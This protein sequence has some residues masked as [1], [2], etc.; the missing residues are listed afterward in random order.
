MRPSSLCFWLAAT[1]S[2]SACANSLAPEELAPRSFTQAPLTVDNG[3]DLNGKDLNGK[4]L[5]GSDLSKFMV[6]VNFNPAKKGG[7]TLDDAWLEG[8]TFY[9]HK[10]SNIYLGEEFVGV[11]FQGN[12]GDGSTVPVR[13]TGMNPAPVPNED[14]LL[15]SLEYRG[16]DG[17]WRP[18]CQDA[19][20]SA[21][22]ALPLEGVW[23]YRQGVAGGGSKTNDSQRFTFACL[24][25]AIAKCALWGYRPWASYNGTPLEAYHQAC[26]RM[27][28]ADYCGTGQSYTKTGNRIN[29]YDELGVQ[30]DSADWMFEAE[31]DVNG[32]RCIYALNRTN[33]SLPCFDSRADLLCGQQLSQSRGALMRNETPGT[34]G[35]DLGL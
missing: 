30:Q 8:T 17:V 7:A 19:A 15:Y 31:W 9:G 2:L 29:F 12:L 22:Q 23:D 28:R 33:A 20:G 21:I 1:L 35:V 13:I 14:V 27:V 4:D 11:E 26:T 24:G 18:T 10:G 3:K 34:L 32:A 5:N 6:S 16:T 25:G